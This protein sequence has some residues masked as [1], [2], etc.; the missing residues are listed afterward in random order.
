VLPW[1]TSQ[2]PTLLAIDEFL[3]ANVIRLKPNGTLPESLRSFNR[4]SFV[5]VIRKYTMDFNVNSNNDIFVTYIELLVT[6]HR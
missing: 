4:E 5:T 2:W 1:Q 6:L 3:R